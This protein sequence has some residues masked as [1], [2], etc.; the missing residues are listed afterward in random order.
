MRLSRIPATTP[1][2]STAATATNRPTG[3]TSSRSGHSRPVTD[4]SA[5]NGTIRGRMWLAKL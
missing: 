1:P 4:T 5:R 3:V 2:I